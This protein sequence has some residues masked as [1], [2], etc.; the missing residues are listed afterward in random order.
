MDG[1]IE[2]AGALVVVVGTLL[3]DGIELPA[4]GAVDIPDGRIDGLAEIDGALDVPFFDGGKLIDGII[5]I[6]GDAVIRADGVTELAGAVVVLFLVDGG[7]LRDGNIELNGGVDMT[8][9]DG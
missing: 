9:V 3:D 1:M 8:L 6:A 4:D 7:W 5:E 2:L